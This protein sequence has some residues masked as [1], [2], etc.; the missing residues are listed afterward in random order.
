MET[1]CKKTLA[2]IPQTASFKKHTNNNKKVNDYDI[3]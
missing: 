2:F 3:N 1:C